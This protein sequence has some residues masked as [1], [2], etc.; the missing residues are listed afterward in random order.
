MSA[1]DKY[2]TSF[3]RNYND[4]ENG[5]L[6]YNINDYAYILSQNG[7]PCTSYLADKKKTF[8]KD[9]HGQIDKAFK[10]AAAQ[11]KGGNKQPDKITPFNNEKDNAKDKEIGII[12]NYDFVDVDG[13]KIEEIKLK[14]AGGGFVICKTK[15]LY[16]LA[17]FKTASLMKR[18]DTQKIKKDE[19]EYKV[20]KKAY[21]Q[22]KK[23]YDALVKKSK[24]KKLK[25]KPPVEPKA[26]NPKRPKT[27]EQPQN[28]GDTGTSVEKC[29]AYLIRSGC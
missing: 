11:K 18:D 20:K 5:H 2:L 4:A 13:Q 23:Q 3:L 10:T 27:I 29:A 6:Y 24:G 28:F 8:A 14:T 19:D 9:L 17:G 1:W 7:A 26:P 16:V 12:I 22:K 15:T 25:A 21:D